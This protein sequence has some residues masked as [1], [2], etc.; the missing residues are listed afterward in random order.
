MRSFDDMKENPPLMNKPDMGSE[1]VILEA[2]DIDRVWAGH[3]V[4]F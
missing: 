2:L 3:P 4:A 1:S